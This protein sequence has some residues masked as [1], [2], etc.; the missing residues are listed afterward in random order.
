MPDFVS[1]TSVSRPIAQRLGSAP[2]ILNVIA[3]FEH[4]VLLRSADAGPF[5]LVSSSVGDGPLNIVLDDTLRHLP[6]VVTGSAARADGRSLCFDKL[7]VNLANAVLWEPRPDWAC[8]R[9]GQQCVADGLQGLLDYAVQ[10]APPRSLLCELS[11]SSRR[12]CAEGEDTD[13]IEQRVA[14]SLPGLR[15]GLAGDA[16]ALRAAVRSLAGLGLGLTP[17]GDDFLCGLMLWCWLTYDDPPHLCAQI[18]Q[19]ATPGTTLLSAAFLRAAARGE[20][21]ASWQCLL[22]D[23][24]LGSANVPLAAVRTVLTHGATSGAD[25]MAGFLWASGVLGS[26]GLCASD[27]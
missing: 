3:S 11:R 20:C 25:A 26:N 22:T 16:V 7:H 17:A 19:A 8:L 12:G 24:C 18:T 23:L 1:A 27:P 5:G 14:A 2:A 6:M 13:P 21:S 9:G 15:A 4:A 10:L